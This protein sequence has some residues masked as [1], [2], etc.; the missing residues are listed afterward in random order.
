ME[1]EDIEIIESHENQ[2]NSSLDGITELFVPSEESILDIFQFLNR[3]NIVTSAFSPETCS[4]DRVQAI[5]SLQG[6]VDSDGQM[7]P[8]LVANTHQK[9]I[10][11]LYFIHEVHAL[12]NSYTIS[13]LFDL[14]FS[15]EILQEGFELFLAY[16]FQDKKAHRIEIDALE[17]HDDSVGVI[18]LLQKAR[19]CFEGIKRNAFTYGIESD[20]STEPLPFQFQEKGDGKWLDVMSFSLLASERDVLSMDT[21]PEMIPDLSSEEN[22]EKLLHKAQYEGI[23]SIIIR[24]VVMKH[25]QEIGESESVSPTDLCLLLLKRKEEPSKRVTEELPGVEFKIGLESMYDALQRVIQ[26][27]LHASIKGPVVYLTSF[28]FLKED[29]CKV[30]EFVFRVNIEGEIVLNSDRHDSFRWVPLQNLAKTPLHPEV[31]TIL[32]SCRDNIDYLSETHLHHDQEVIIEEVRS[33]L[34]ELFDS[35]AHGLHVNAYA[36]RG[37]G[38]QEMVGISLRDRSG[39]LIGGVLGETQYGGYYC[40]KLWVDPQFWGQG[41]EGRVIEHIENIAREKGAKFVIFSLMDWEMIRPLQRKGYRIEW[42]RSGYDRGSK[43]IYLRK[44]IEAKK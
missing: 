5:V 16:M 35:L 7:V 40:Q 18:Q 21:G 1:R 44:E 12:Y 11:A 15:Q 41:W 37:F 24:A 39:R 30:R 14:E 17:Q 9:K 26:Q 38:V 23:S 10:S 13:A 36:A 6:C 19:F 4:I 29:A 42:Q 31:M 25:R 8:G 20:G 33:P 27:E 3:Q 34:S 28:D 22:N 32:F 2:D 43:L